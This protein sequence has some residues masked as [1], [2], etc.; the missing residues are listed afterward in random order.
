MN[1]V[2][3]L[4]SLAQLYVVEFSDVGEGLPGV[5]EFLAEEGFDTQLAPLLDRDANAC[6][7]VRHLEVLFVEEPV[8]GRRLRYVDCVHGLVREAQNF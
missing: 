1:F 3:F 4:R 5:L 2:H 6:E 8:K 7:L